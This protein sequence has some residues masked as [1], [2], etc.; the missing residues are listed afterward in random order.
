MIHK[1]FI[2]FF[3]IFFSNTA[4][5]QDFKS[6]Y[7]SGDISFSQKNYYGASILYKR[8]LD[9]NPDYKQIAWKY[10]ESCR[11]GKNYNEAIKWYR[12]VMQNDTTLRNPELLFHLAASY[13]SVGKYEEAAK[14]YTWYF[15]ANSSDN[16]FMVRKAIHEAKVCKRLSARALSVDSTV[17]IQKIKGNANSGY[18]EYSPAFRNDSMLYFSSYRPLTDTLEFV[19]SIFKSSLSDSVWNEG[20]RI[21]SMVNKGGY[22]IANLSFSNQGNTMYFTLCD[23]NKSHRKCEIYRSFRV[24]NRWSEAEKLPEK[25]NAKGAINTHPSLAKTE[26]GEY[27]FFASNRSG[28]FGH[29]DIWYCKIYDN[30]LFSEVQHCDSSI[31][32]PGNEITP[33][34]VGDTVLYFSSDWLPGLGGYDIFMAYKDNEKWQPAINAG[35][36]LNSSYDDLYYNISTNKRK[37]LF[38]SNRE[39]RNENPQNTCCND[40]YEQIL[41]IKE[42]VPEKDTTE[43]ILVT[44]EIDTIP[45]IAVQV[46]NIGTFEVY[47]DN[48]QPLPRSRDTTTTINYK[49]TYDNYIKQKEYYRQMYS[50]GFDDENKMRAKNDI[51]TLF[52]TIAEG[53]KELETFCSQA[54]LL[55]AKGYKI[56]VLVSGSASPLH[57][58]RYN[59]KLSKRRI[60]C[61]RN[62]FNEY[63]NGKLR[64]FINEGELIIKDLPVS[65][66]YAK[67]NISD[68][69]SD[70]RNSI[71]NPEAALERKVLL[72]INK[73]MVNF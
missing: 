18:S 54:T 20:S 53:F 7:K 42:P 61:V 37:A 14:Y 26:N 19:S 8:I 47:F 35:I 58:S 69:K 50:S 6:Y 17:I 10:A 33:Y 72:I 9:N 12:Y 68:S 67:K 1:L 43:I 49:E 34:F 55:C 27:L 56:E 63:D 40:I 28:G 31:N 24:K 11:M 32:T 15:S 45:E 16:S 71:F 52:G 2:F 59:L 44:T 4:I 46:A 39:G 38:V 21:G 48:D 41:K 60:A 25:I 73:V 57:S 5:A 62:Y 65:D 30:V 66:Y 51:D 3:V 23:E 36:P 13:K 64:K 29:L 22:N 70:L